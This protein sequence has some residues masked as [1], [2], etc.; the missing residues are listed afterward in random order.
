MPFVRPVVSTPVDGSVEYMAKSVW[1]GAQIVAQLDTGYHWSGSTITY[2]FPANAN[3]FPFGEK[4]GFSALNGNQQAAATLAIGLWDDLI[5]PDFSLAGNASTA[6]IKFSNTTTDIGYAHAYFPGGW[7]GAGSVWFNSNY[8][9]G[10][11]TGNLMSPQA[12]QWGFLAYVHELGHALG[13]DH[14]GNY[15]GGSPT[16][17]ANAL[18]AQDS[19]KYTVMSYFTANNTGA[20]WV[21]SDGQIHYAQTPMLHDVMTIQA[22]YGAETTTRAGSTT[23]GFNSSAGGLYDFSTNGHPVL[24]IYD[25]GGNDTLDLSGWNSSCVINLAPGSYSNCDQMTSNLAIAFGTWIENAVGGGG[26]DTLNGNGL[27]NVLSGLA[28][29]DNID[30]KAGG[31]TL[32]GGGGNDTLAGGAG[33]D[34]LDGGSGADNMRGGVGS[35]TYVV[36]STGDVVTELAS[37]GSDLVQT[38]LSSYTLPGN[39]EKLTYIG[40]G[41]FT[42]RGNGLK[43]VITGGAGSDDLSGRAGNDVLIGGAGTDTLRGGLGADRFYFAL[44]SESGLGAAA[45][46]ISDFSSAQL[47]KIDVSAIDANPG[48][49]GDDAFVFLGGAAFSGAAGELR[50]SGGYVMADLD[51]DMISDFEISLPNVSQLLASNFVL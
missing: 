51:G 18:Y 26:S 47:D 27:A 43:N 44:A 6:K 38:D 29:S 50:F 13:L 31:D 5:A 45:D 14:P 4:S 48:T 11:G 7:S 17:A 34:I 32:Y 35:D 25:A 28:A 16:Y 22:M 1:T 8:G 24:C 21:A 20:D 49:A 9:A 23:Y 33:N 3:W 19:Q 42:G 36:D 15:N 10:S 39:V 30:G 41:S 2:G 12:G 37:A 46:V 40:A